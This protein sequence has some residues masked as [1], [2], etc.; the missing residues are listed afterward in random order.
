M[1]KRFDAKHQEI[2]QSC[3]QKSIEAMHQDRMESFVSERV[4][5]VPSQR[6]IEYLLDA[7]PILQEYQQQQDENALLKANDGDDEDD[8]VECVLDGTMR[9]FVHVK[10]KTKDVATLTKLK[11]A[12]AVQER[13]SK[14]YHKAQSAQFQLENNLDR[15]EDVCQDCQVPLL[16]VSVESNLV[17]PECGKSE[18]FTDGT[19]LT[20]EQEVNRVVIPAFAYKRANH[21]SDWLAQFQGKESTDIP[22]EIIDALRAEF[23]KARITSRKEIMPTKVRALLKKLNYS[24]YYEHVPYIMKLLG[25]SPPCM[26][27]ELEDKIRQMF[28]QCQAPFMKHR[29]SSRKN[30]LSYPYFLY[31][32]C[33]LLGEDKFLPCFPLLKSR[34]K[35]KGHDQLWQAICAELNWEY[36][37][38]M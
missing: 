30:F 37:S 28:L 5:G 24:K 33:Q 7:A 3:C 32:S 17:C 14:A 2:M 15:V 11:L 23:R 38:S 34:G 18:F 9:N 1:Q 25:V 22:E 36:I 6:E 27:K 20:Y 21:L 35:L 8:M 31:K 13:G 4:G 29:P 10:R 19:S 16:V 12:T 26:S